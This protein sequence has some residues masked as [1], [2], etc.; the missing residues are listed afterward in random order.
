[1]AVKG[2]NR[3]SWAF[4]MDKFVDRD[5]IISR[6][7]NVDASLVAAVLQQLRLEYKRSKRRGHSTMHAT[8]QKLHADNEL[9]G[10]CGRSQ[11]MA[12]SHAAYPS[13]SSWTETSGGSRREIFFHIF[14]HTTSHFDVL[15]LGRQHEGTRALSSLFLLECE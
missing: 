9:R 1:M 11:H 13:Y 10:T 3:L 12:H 2:E 4:T 15:Y 8:L 14:L 6:A 7:S 5:L